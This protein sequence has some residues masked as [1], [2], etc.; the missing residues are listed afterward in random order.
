MLVNR[1][2]KNQRRLKRW[3]KASGV[4]CY[5]LYDRDIP[6][7]PLAIDLY[8]GRLHVSEYTRPGSPEGARHTAWMET[9]LGGLAD[10]LGV[11]AAD[12]FVKLRERK[13]GTA[14]YGRFGRDGATYQVS[15]GGH[16]F[17]VNLSDYLDTGLF[18]DHRLTRARAAADCD[19]RRVLNLYAYT[20]SF[21]VYAAGAG[22]S[23]TTTVDMSSTYCDWARA[24]FEFNGM[25]ARDHAVVR[26]DVK[27]WLADAASAGRRWDMAFVDPPTFSNSKKM[28]GVFD[29]Q[30]DHLGLLGAVRDVLTPGGVV[31][32]S[33][34]FRKFKL[35]PS[36]NAV[37]YTA[38]TTPPDFRNTRIHRA[39]RI[40]L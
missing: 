33:T 28:T 38:E 3:L 12:V 20:G 13:R 25:A 5:R 24:N 7:I 10:G 21:S 4:T 27:T 14:Q 34:N 40:V 26:A 22:A 31:W 19:G 15:E 39:Y 16:L 17:R 9:L 11:S 29:V 35:D 8:E 37:D 18:L 2:R 23:D 30:R 36:I 32:F 6:E 1:I